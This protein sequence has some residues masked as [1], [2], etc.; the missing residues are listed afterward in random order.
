M[1]KV[2]SLAESASFKAGELSS[3]FGS[4]KTQI[5]SQ[6]GPNGLI[7]AYFVAAVLVLFIG[8]KLV[9][10]TFSAMKYLVVPSVGLAI[11]GSLVLPLSFVMILPVTVTMCSL[12]LL[13][14]G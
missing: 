14:K 9:K 12:V 3:L 7:A 6:F 4:V 5:V 11:V 1:A 10:L 2:Q 13:F 8:A